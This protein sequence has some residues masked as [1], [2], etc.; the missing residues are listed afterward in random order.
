MHR[1]TDYISFC[2]RKANNV[3]ND[4]FKSEILQQIKNNYGY[5]IDYKPYRVLNPSIIKCVDKNPHIL[6]VRTVGN[7]Y[8]LYLTQFDGVNYCLFIDKK[9]EA[10]KHN[11]PRI[12]HANYNFSQELY[13]GTLL[14]GELI[15]DTTNNWYFVLSDILVYKNEVLQNKI[16]TNKTE[17]LYYILQNQYT[18][19][20]VTDV[21][22]FQVKKLF[23]Y[24]DV[25]YLLNNFIP[26]LPY[27]IRGI[28]FNTYN[29]KY[30]SYIY[31][32]N[33]DEQPKR[34]INPDNQERRRPYARPTE[35]TNRIISTFKIIQT[36]TS[37]IY[38]LY[39]LNGSN[40]FK[41]G[42]AYVGD[43]SHRQFLKNTCNK[44]GFDT[45][46]DCY[47]LPK[48]R[49][50]K[51]FQVSTNTSPDQLDQIKNNESLSKD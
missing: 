15:H 45:H 23:S 20:L 48:R 5:D 31:L 50:W 4:Q 18:P 28:C 13:T 11:F 24:K 19:N 36:N 43:S 40:V 8:F 1:A 35:N 2:D 37:E 12:L 42:V 47:Y 41:Y 39:C 3:R 16:I 17:L 32:L 22:P 25:D 7:S 14:E 34:V 29:A 46:V 21:C 33:K 10:P 38:D 27:G 6:S 44:K 30:S 49:K 9:I 51:P 26:N